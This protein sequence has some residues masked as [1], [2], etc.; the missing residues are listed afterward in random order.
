[1]WAHNAVIRMRG[2]VIVHRTG[3]LPEFKFYISLYEFNWLACLV[4]ISFLNKVGR[5][6]LLN[7]HCGRLLR[8]YACATS[9]I[10]TQ[11]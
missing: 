1:M 10:R 9:F 2:K 4:W 7:R 3:V 5:R 8:C 11:I 6:D